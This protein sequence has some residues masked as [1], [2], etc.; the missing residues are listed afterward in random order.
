MNAHELAR[1]L[2]EGPDLPVYVRGYEG[3]V[4]DIGLIEPIEVVRDAYSDTSYYGAHDHYGT[5]YVDDDDEHPVRES[6]LWLRV[7]DVN[8]QK[9]V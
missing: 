7:A 3:G 5:D 2:L 1:K 8:D 4:D 9:V 6:G